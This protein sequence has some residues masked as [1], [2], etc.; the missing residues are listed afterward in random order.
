MAD[1]DFVDSIAEIVAVWGN[2]LTE[3]ITES[4]G[5]KDMIASGV[6]AQSFKPSVKIGEDFVEFTLEAPSYYD[7]LDKG[8]KRWTNMKVTNVAPTFVDSIV[9]W[10]RTKGI[11]ATIPVKKQTLASTI[12]NKKMVIKK[13]V[14]PKTQLEANKQMAFNI[15]SS[16]K[17]N[18]V[19]KRFGYKGSNF[20]SE[21]VNE[22]AFLELRKTIIK[23]TANPNFILQFI[24]PAKQ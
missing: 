19:I 15:V 22:K 24:D 3:D 4:L 23:H 12:K 14:K 7:V 5:K 13:V 1:K 21:V 11:Q 8:G 16:I 20:Y 18:G 6:T 17:K 10:M 9:S 2:K